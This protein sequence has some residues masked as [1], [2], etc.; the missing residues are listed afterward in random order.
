MLN[1]EKIFASDV[2]TKRQRV[3]RTLNHQSVDRVAIHEQLSFNPGVIAL[4]TGK[5]TQGFDYTLDDICTVIRKTLDTCFVPTAPLGTGRET[6]EDGF[7][8]QHDNWN[9]WHVSRPF[10]DEKGACAWLERKTARLASAPFNPVN[11]K[12]EYR[13]KMRTL[14]EKVG[15]T[16]IIDLSLTG[17]CHV[18]DDMGL[19]LYSYFSLDYPQ[20]LRDYLDATAAAEIRRIHAVADPAISPVILIAEDFASKHGPLFSPAFLES[21]HFP[22]IA[23]VAKAWHDHGIKVLYHSDGNYK[24]VIPDLIACGLDGFYCLEPNCGMDVVALKRE[25]PNIVWAGSLDGVDLMERGTP[26]Q[27]C[28]EAI[29]QINETDALRTG[30]FLLATSSEI[31]PPI[32]PENFKAMIDAAGAVWNPDFMTAKAAQ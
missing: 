3:E 19:E 10:N 7:V 5:N 11:A 12:K 21:Y 17:F 27:V 16:V 13:Q 30:G 23:R 2:L 14:Q 29:R 31:N 9:T 26:Q 8:R 24:K 20:V 1:H 28:Q 32:K 22:Y 18:F 4:Y 6:D 15:E 25:H